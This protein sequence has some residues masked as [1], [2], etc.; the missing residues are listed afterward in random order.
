M[1]I[2]QE[3]M[4]LA[5]KLEQKLQE[6]ERVCKK[7]GYS[8][9]T[10]ISLDGKIGYMNPKGIT[11]YMDSKGN[12]IKEGVKYPMSCAISF[13]LK[14]KYAPMVFND[15]IRGLYPC[16]EGLNPS[17]GSEGRWTKGYVK[18][19]SSSKCQFDSGTSY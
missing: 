4:D 17:G 3:V 13:S 10:V 12:E 8:E 6:Q 18:S 1:K 2:R 16:G 19:P 7:Y 15:S 11:W 9:C 14:Q 5:E